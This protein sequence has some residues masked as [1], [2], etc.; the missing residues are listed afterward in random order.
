MYVPSN[1]WLL[2]GFWGNMANPS[3][4]TINNLNKVFHIFI[5]VLDDKNEAFK[6]FVFCPSMI[7][8]KYPARAQLVITLAFIY[9]LSR[10]VLETCGNL[11]E[12]IVNLFFSSIS[13]TNPS[14]TTEGLPWLIADRYGYLSM[15]TS[16]S[17]MPDLVLLVCL[18]CWN[19]LSGFHIK[20][21][22]LIICWSTSPFDTISETL[23]KLWVFYVIYLNYRIPWIK[24]WN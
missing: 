18:N 12:C 13:L 5:F 1:Y 9:N 24:Y 7:I 3:F 23:I 22:K 8:I 6:F 10:T 16:V 2:F 21:R 14:L 15:L 19:F 17:D 11:S 4:I 20:E